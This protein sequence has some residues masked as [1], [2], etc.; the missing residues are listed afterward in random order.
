VIE[1]YFLRCLHKE[2]I[3]TKNSPIIQD[4][5]NLFDEKTRM[6]GK[7]VYS[8]KWTSTFYTLRELVQLGVHPNCKEFQMGLDTLVNKIWMSES[9]LKTD[10]CILAMLV[11]LFAYAKRDGLMIHDILLHILN[12][13]QPDGGWNCAY[14]RHKTVVSSINTTLAVLEALRD[15]QALGVIPI[16]DIDSYIKQG[17]DYLLRKK[18]YQRE[19]TG[20]PIKSYVTKIHFPIRWQYDLYRALEYFK[21]VE[22]PYTEAMEDALQ[23]VQGS[24]KNGLMPKGPQFSGDVHFTYELEFYKKINTIRALSILKQYKYQVYEDLINIEI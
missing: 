2:R 15:Y 6:W 19:T 16:D 7:G 1:S 20:K 24:F 22:Y 13:Q 5:L 18:I 3:Y 4:F 12:L 17:Q 10:I 9:S 23:L 8:S 21:S 14:N 11:S